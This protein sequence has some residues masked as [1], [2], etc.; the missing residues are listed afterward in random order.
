MKGP[1]AV[2]RD[3]RDYSKVDNGEENGT[4]DGSPSHQTRHNEILSATPRGLALGVFWW[5]KFLIDACFSTIMILAI[6]ANM[7]QRT[8]PCPAV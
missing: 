8:V 1:W 3:T 4:G 6:R 7:G 5:I 2:F